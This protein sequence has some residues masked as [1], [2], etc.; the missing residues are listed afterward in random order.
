MRDLNQL[1]S[2]F[3][4]RKSL[5]DRKSRTRSH[6]PEIEAS[7]RRPLGVER[8]AAFLE[9]ARLY[10]PRRALHIGALRPRKTVVS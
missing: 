8:L 4:V 7:G 10:L 3:L 9:R 5:D 6:M 1:Y 2:E